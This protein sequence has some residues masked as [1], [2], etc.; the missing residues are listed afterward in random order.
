[1]VGAATDT[2]ANALPVARIVK[3]F[4]MDFSW[5]CPYQQPTAWHRVPAWEQV[6][7]QARVNKA[8]RNGELSR[9]KS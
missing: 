1:V 2:S 3:N 6:D 9:G 7:G 4:V 5:Y 8:K